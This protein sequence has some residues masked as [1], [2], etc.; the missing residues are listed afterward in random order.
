MKIL[1][2]ST[3][4]LGHQPVNLAY[5][6]AM[7]RADGFRV[8]QSDLAVDRFD[9]EDLQDADLVAISVPM[10]TA[11]RLTVPLIARIRAVRPQLHIALYGLYAIMNRDYFTTLGVDSILGRDAASE[12]LALSRQMDQRPAGQTPDE[13][14]LL[15]RRPRLPERH[16]LPDLDR[17]A[18]LQLPDGSRKTVGY[19]E[20]SVGCKHFC[21]HCP[22][23]PVYQGRFRAIPRENVLADIRQ[24]V[25]SG[26][27]HIT[28]GDPDFLNG[29]THA[30]RLIEALHAEFPD[31][32]YDV[33]VKVEHILATPGLLP[34]LKETGCLWIT[35]AV[36]SVDDGILERLAKGH[37]RSDIF[38]LM[39]LLDEAGLDLSPTFVAFTPWTTAAD[40][41]DLLRV[42]A[43]LGLIESV[44]PVQYSIRLL[45]PPGSRLLE[46]EEIRTLVKPLQQASFL[47]P[48]E[49]P[50]PRLDLL[51]EAIHEIAKQSAADSRQGIFAKIW[52]IA[53]EIFGADTPPIPPGPRRKRPAQLSEPWYC[54]A[55][56]TALQ[57]RFL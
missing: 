31:L 50:D 22:V 24:Q 33:T 25:D 35:S 11:A 40:Y 21:R 54:C 14:R 45:I 44:S 28:F 19:V 1:L 43:E 49:S 34:I 53:H 12:L 57:Y 37:R 27:K 52:R 10:H 51:H 4:E 20:A 18:H 30:R 17:Y 46:L 36:E 26:A 55:E 13:A 15:D 5:P 3:Y 39:H 48:W 41:I 42:I 9:R 23:V 32:S 38:R 16:D 8:Q 6:A 47:Y 56:P 29:P 2:I 7:L